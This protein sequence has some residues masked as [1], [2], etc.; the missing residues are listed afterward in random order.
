MFQQAEAEPE[1]EVDEE[2]VEAKDIDLVMQ[3]ANVNR[4]KAVTALKKN[5]GDI[6]NAIMVRLNTD[7]S[8]WLELTLPYVPGADH[9]GHLRLLLASY[10]V[11]LRVGVLLLPLLA[12]TIGK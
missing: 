8:S 12:G 6:V 2:G 10:T 1:G 3:Q 9:V 4:S 11:H 7:S 5:G